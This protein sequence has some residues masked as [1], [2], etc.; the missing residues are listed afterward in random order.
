MLPSTLFKL[1]DSV[2]RALLLRAFQLSLDYHIIEL[3]E[4]LGL[5]LVLFRIENLPDALRLVLYRE[6]NVGV[7]GELSALVVRLYLSIN[8]SYSSL[9]LLGSGLRGRVRIRF[10]FCLFVSVRGLEIRVNTNS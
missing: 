3:H 4:N 8:S 5:L 2:V 1:A 9:D 6:Q 7:S 10:V